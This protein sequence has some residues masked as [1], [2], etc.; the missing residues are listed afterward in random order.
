MWRAKISL[1]LNNLY[2]KKTILTTLV[3]S[4]LMFAWNTYADE[5]ILTTTS[6]MPTM[7]MVTTAVETGSI[8]GDLSMKYDLIIRNNNILSD[9]EHNNKSYYTKK[10]TTA[11]IVVPEE[12]TKKAK[13][14][15]FL[16]E[17]GYSRMFY[18]K[19]MAWVAD[20]ATNVKKEYNYKIVDFTP[21]K[22]KYTFNTVD[23]VKDLKDGEYK[24]VTIT[25]VAE[26]SDT[27]KLYLSNMAYIN[28]ADKQNIL[29]TLKYE[30]DPSGTSYFGYYDTDSVWKYLEKLGEKMT[31]EKYKATL[32]KVQTKLKTLIAKN[33]D[34]K[35]QILKS[36][37]KEADFATNLDK[38]IVYSE[39]SNLLNNVS[40]ATIN[41]LQKLRSYDLIDSV[42][43]K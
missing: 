5:A 8:S 1:Y 10:I 28:I 18:N 11:D 43:G 16:V 12:V 4:S 27:D 26:F 13:R 9:D 37:T 23:L 31:R 42:F 7:D 24:S 29:E 15:Y 2:M 6:A 32:T 19:E 14:V 39:T 17:E 41:Q 38:Y 25:L 3:A 22:T 34:S 20:E 33:E 30:K 40:G 35:K 21:W 36:I